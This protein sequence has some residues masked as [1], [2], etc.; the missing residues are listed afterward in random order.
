MKAIIKGLK[1]YYL[2]YLFLL[3]AFTIF[4]LYR[5]LPLLWNVILSFQEW[6]PLKKNEYIGLENYIEMFED[7]VFWQSFSNMVVL[8]FAGAIIAIV[9]ALF[10]ALLL[11]S[12]LRGRY[13]YRTIF[14]IPY[15]L[16]PVAIAI[17]WKWLFNKNIGLINYLLLETGLIDE[18]ISFLS[19]FDMALPSIIFV[20]I[21]RMIGYYI[22]LLLTGLQLIPESLYEAADIDGANHKEKLLNI[23]LPLIKS[24]FF[25]CFIVGI[26][27]S[28]TMFDVIY[29]MTNGGPGHSTE[30]IVTYIYKNAF[31]F[32]NLGYSAALTIFLF[33]FFVIVT[34][35]VNK[36]SG[37]EAGGLKHYD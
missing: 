3:P 19:S 10:I 34:F 24:T 28:F 33:V 29:N 9:M 35:V 36:I 11:N 16:T 21:W 12:N 2:L 26:I 30:I 7:G 18:K 13:I 6:K 32:S 31:K 22:I 17:I 5:I 4:F 37:G 14:F 27:N 15:P 20:T 1:K 25:I 23:T 8:F